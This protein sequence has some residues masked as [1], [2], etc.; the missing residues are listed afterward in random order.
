MIHAY[1]E[2]Y[3]YRSQ[4]N[5]AMAF[6]IALRHKNLD[7]TEFSRIFAGSKEVQQ[8]ERG[9]PLFS[10]ACPG[11]NCYA[12]YWTIMIQESTIPISNLGETI[13]QDMSWP[14]SSGIAIAASQ[15]SL[16][17]CLWNVFWSFITH[18]MRWISNSSGTMHGSLS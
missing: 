5:L 7:P 13:G 4:K 1:Y 11:Q 18:I 15:R 16:K 2:D 9:A 8:F 3:L 14:I 17:S 12:G 6:D 10:S